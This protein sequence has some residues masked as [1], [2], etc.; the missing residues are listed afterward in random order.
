MAY[1]ALGV[2]YGNLD[3]TG[4]MEENMT[5]AFSLRSRSTEAESLRIEA[6]YYMYVIG[7]RY[8]GMEV[9]RLVK[10]VYPQAAYPYNHI[11]VAYLGLGQYEKALGGRP[12]VLPE[13]SHR[14]GTRRT[15]Q[16]FSSTSL[17]CT[18]AEK[19][20]AEG[21][22]RHL[23]PPVAAAVVLQPRIFAA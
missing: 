9:Y 21:E 3:Q 19:L 2:V 5:K 12:G 14:H 1:Q 6:A 15:W 13:K 8:K 11:G 18:E 7:D 23:R 20:L 4:L 16:A 17:G 22:T 10:S